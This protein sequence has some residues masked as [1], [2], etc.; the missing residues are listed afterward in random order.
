MAREEGLILDD[1]LETNPHLLHADV[2]AIVARDTFGVEDEQVLNAISN[3][4]LGSPR[5]SPLSCIVFLADS[6]EL[7]EAIL[8]L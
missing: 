3:H 1:I 2:S 6:I 4:T 5:M 8:L 7:V